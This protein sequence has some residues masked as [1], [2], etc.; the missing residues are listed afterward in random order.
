MIKPAPVFAVDAGRSVTVCGAK[1]VLV[2]GA[3]VWL[4][5]CLLDG[6]TRHR[7]WT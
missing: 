1:T 6:G 7:D 4:A 2:L 3:P 5:P